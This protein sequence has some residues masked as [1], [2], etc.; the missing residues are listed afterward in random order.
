MFVIFESFCEASIELVVGII[1]LGVK[2]RLAMEAWSL[3][4]I[5]T[6]A[7]GSASS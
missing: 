2:K 6:F 5:L 1:T 3:K 7:T 4:I